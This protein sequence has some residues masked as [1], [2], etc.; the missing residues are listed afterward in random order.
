MRSWMARHPFLT[1]LIGIAALAGLAIWES[2]RIADAQATVPQGWLTGLVSGV[3]GGVALMAAGYPAIKLARR[4]PAVTWIWAVV[5]VVAFGI[6]FRGTAP[7]PNAPGPYVITTGIG[8]AGMAF[9]ATFA[10]QCLGLCV[11]VV[12]RRFRVRR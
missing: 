2:A 8:V 7:D 1:L 10:A 6:A 11:L 12:V 9:T 5:L 3:A 4:A